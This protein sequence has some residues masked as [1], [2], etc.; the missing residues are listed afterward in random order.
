MHPPAHTHTCARPSHASA[1]VKG[2]YFNLREGGARSM[3]GGND[4]PLWTTEP[5][6]G[7][8]VCRRGSCL[9]RGMGEQG[10]GRVCM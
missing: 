1:Q 7:G 2:G 8:R 3:T 10:P 4:Q 5:E 9:R 6:V